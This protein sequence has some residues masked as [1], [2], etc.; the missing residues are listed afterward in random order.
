MQFVLQNGPFD[1]YE[2]DYPG[3]IGTIIATA[4]SELRWAHL[5][6]T[7]LIL[8]GDHDGQLLTHDQVVGFRAWLRSGLIDLPADLPDRIRHLHGSVRNN[9]G[10]KHAYG[11][12]TGERDALKFI[13]TGACSIKGGDRL[14]L[15]TDGLGPLWDLLEWRPTV[16]GPVPSP[17]AKCLRE[18][19]A[20]DLVDIAEDAETRTSS[21][22]SDDKTV[23][24]VDVR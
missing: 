23:V 22:R 17:V 2:H 1:L 8:I 19:T 16:P 7:T 10:L 4:G 6:D 14:V 21:G 24:V 9:S 18:S 3:T 5:G 15:A 12:L 13:E 11:V 20:Q